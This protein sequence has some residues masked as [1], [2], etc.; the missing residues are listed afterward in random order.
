[1]LTI[2]SVHGA[3]PGA[4]PGRGWSPT[5]GHR[6]AP[7]ALAAFGLP[8]YAQFD[9]ALVFEGT[10][11]R[12]DLGRV[13]GSASRWVSRR[14][15]R[16]LGIGFQA[17]IEAFNGRWRRACRERPDTITMASTRD[18]STAWL[19]AWRAARAVRIEAAPAGRVEQFDPSAAVHRGG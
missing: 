8:G 15:T 6:I 7:R 5:A 14:S 4:W 18:R 16:H 12:P 2:I 19:E 11:A 10:H 1:M 9:N 17:G 3:L 13:R